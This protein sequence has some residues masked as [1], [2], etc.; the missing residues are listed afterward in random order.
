[1]LKRRSRALCVAVGVARTAHKLQALRGL[2]TLAVGCRLAAI[3]M[4]AVEGAAVARRSDC[5]ISD[6]SRPVSEG[7]VVDRRDNSGTWKA[8][9]SVT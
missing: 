8:R 7:R 5:T 3:V 6:T 9:A 1:M 4:L 2:A